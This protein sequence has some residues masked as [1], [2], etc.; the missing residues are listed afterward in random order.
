MNWLSQRVASALDSRRSVPRSSQRP[1]SGRRARTLPSTDFE[2]QTTYPPISP[3]GDDVYVRRRARTREL[4]RAA[5]AD[6]VLA[7]SGTANFSYLVGGDFG[8][9]ERRRATR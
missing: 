7:T 2:V 1:G 3:L 6:V 4:A 9:S 8:R 5:K